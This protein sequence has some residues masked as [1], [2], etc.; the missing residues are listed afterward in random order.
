MSTSGPALFLPAEERLMKSIPNLGSRNNSI[1]KIYALNDLICV[2]NDD[3]ATV[4][5]SSMESANNPYII[6]ARNI[7]SSSTDDIYITGTTKHFRIENCSVYVCNQGI[8]VNS[9]ASGTV[10]ITNNTCN[11]NEYSGI[12]INSSYYLIIANN[13]CNN[14]TEYGMSVFGLIVNSLKI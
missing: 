4:T 8:V 2:T 6:T 1:L 9:V 12:F 5:N 3:I 11:N 14:N 13:I 10:T 7:M